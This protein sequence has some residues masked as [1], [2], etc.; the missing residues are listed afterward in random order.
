MNR[1]NCMDY[2]EYDEDEC[3]DRI[4]NEYYEAL[5]KYCSELEKAL[6]KA[7]GIM[8]DRVN[9]D[10]GNGKPTLDFTKEQWKEWLMNNEN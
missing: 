7:C 1:P 5:E 4:T 8:V 3:D 2:L 6:D 9:I 10:S